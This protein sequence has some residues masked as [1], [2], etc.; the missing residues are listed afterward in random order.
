MVGPNLDHSGCSPHTYSLGLEGLP[1]VVVVPADRIL[2]LVGQ[3]TLGRFSHRIT[4]I[5]Q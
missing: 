2:H 1:R 4:G 3:D 5:T